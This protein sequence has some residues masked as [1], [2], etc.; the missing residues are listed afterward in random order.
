ME[1]VPGRPKVEENLPDQSTANKFHLRYLRAEKLKNQKVK[2]KRPLP[3]P[4]QKT[5]PKHFNSEPNISLKC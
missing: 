1:A 4:T 5:H 2:I 3:A